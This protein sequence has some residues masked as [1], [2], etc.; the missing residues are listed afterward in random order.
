MHICE[1]VSTTRCIENLQIA[2]LVD[3]L[4]QGKNNKQR[5]EYKIL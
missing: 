2:I 3:F 4:K 5:D 1:K